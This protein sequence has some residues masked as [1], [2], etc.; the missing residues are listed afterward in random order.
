MTRTNTI[1]GIVIL[2]VLAGALGYNYALATQEP[3]VVVETVGVLNGTATNV[4]V[5]FNGSPYR[6]DL[7]LRA[8]PALQ[9]GAI[10]EPSSEP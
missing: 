3:R 6:C 7:T 5:L 1:S 10:C 4:L 8:D 9:D 2:M